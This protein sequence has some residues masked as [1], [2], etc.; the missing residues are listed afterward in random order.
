MQPYK[1]VI[2]DFFFF[3]IFLIQR[4]RETTSHIKL[5]S[6]TTIVYIMFQINDNNFPFFFFNQQIV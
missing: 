6:C 1:T 5:K 2:F 3:F 4:K